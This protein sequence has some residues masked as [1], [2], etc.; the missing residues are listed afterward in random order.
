MVHRLTGRSRHFLNP[1]DAKGIDI[2]RIVIKLPLRL[3]YLNIPFA[4]ICCIVTPPKSQI[5]TRFTV[6]LCGHC[7]LR[8]VMQYSEGEPGSPKIIFGKARKS[9]TCRDV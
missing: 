8:S 9:L 7:T 2:P 1:G 3:D 6:K 5:E 4:A